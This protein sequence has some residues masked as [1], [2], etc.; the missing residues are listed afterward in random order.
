VN[1]FIILSIT[2]FGFILLQIIMRNVL[3]RKGEKC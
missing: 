2:T 3:S 1:T